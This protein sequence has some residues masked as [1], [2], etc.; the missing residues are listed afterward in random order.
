MGCEATVEGL[1]VM[2]DFFDTRPDGLEVIEG[3]RMGV[4]CFKVL[5]LRGEL[6]KVSDMFTGRINATPI[7]KQNDAGVWMVPN[8][9]M[10][11]YNTTHSLC[12]FA[13]LYKAEGFT[14]FSSGGVQDVY[15]RVEFRDMELKRKGE[16][17]GQ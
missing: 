14:M 10:T 12:D 8:I 15:K 7:F 11:P 5:I 1:A 3:D 17:D 6:V 16:A 2:G 9:L 13:L 4:V